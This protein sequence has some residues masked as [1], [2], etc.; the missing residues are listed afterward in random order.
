MA[1]GGLPRTD[2]TIITA[3]ADGSVLLVVAQHHK[4]LE[5]FIYQC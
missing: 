1:P 5:R 3:F 4:L 2:A